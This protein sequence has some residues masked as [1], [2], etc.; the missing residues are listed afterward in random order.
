MR[1]IFVVTITTGSPTGTAPPASPVP[2]PRAT[3]G[4]PCR[5]AMRTAAA[6]SSVDG[7]KHATAASPASTDAS[8]PYRPSSTPP[9]RTRSGASAA[10][11]SAASAVCA[12]WS[13]LTPAVCRCRPRLGDIRWA[14]PLR[15]GS[16]SGW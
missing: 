10:A 1:S 15:G 3:N 11:R 13:E 5:R 6:T 12:A 2:E 7:G 8:R 14:G 4:R 9:V 16:Q